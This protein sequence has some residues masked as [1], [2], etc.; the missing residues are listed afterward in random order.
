MKLR[1]GAY[2]LSGDPTWLASSLSRY[3]DLLDDLV[4]M[5]PRDG[6]SWTG[7]PLPVRECL[8]AVQ[9][10]DH[11]H[12]ARLVT[13][14]W[15]NVA[16]PMNAE[17][18]Q[19]LD[20]LSALADMD[21]VIQIDNDE[22]LP[23]PHRLVEFIQRAQAVDAEAVWWPMRVLFRRTSRYRYL[24][25]VDRS[26]EHQ[27]EY[28][29]PVAIRPSAVL[30]DGRRPSEGMPSLRPRVSS[31]PRVDSDAPTVLDEQDLTITAAE[32][33][34]HNS[35]GRDARSVW[36][37]IGSSGHRLGGAKGWLYFFLVW[38]PA[39]LTWRWLRSF[40]PLKGDWWPRLSPWSVPQHL[41]AS[42]DDSK[43]V[44]AP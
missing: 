44:G 35:W 23:D 30:M 39:P 19:R 8:E 41:L 38:L 16:N 17:I 18:A 4:V 29:G 22:I 24:S 7:R 13:G 28:P 5:V 33:I 26:G 31:T 40:H 25:V 3:Y 21:W 32:A 9:A 37:K 36:R 15:L 42:A 12:K 43:K 20:G 27:F 11:N 2:L 34:I 1:I 10:V 14:H 6:R